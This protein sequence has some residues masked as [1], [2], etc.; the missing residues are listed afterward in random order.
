MYRVQN[1]ITLAL[2][3]TI[4]VLLAIALLPFSPSPHP[5]NLR[6]LFHAFIVIPFDTIV[7]R[8]K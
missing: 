8:K 2:T 5:P 4:E 3:P 7:C 1:S 6:V